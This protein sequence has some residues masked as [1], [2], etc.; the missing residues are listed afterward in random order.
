MANDDPVKRR[1]SAEARQEEIVRV[2]VEL[3]ASRGVDAVTTQ[4]MADALGL[5]QGAIFRHFPTKD[6]IWVAVIGWVRGQ[7]LPLLEKAASQ[8]D[9]PIDA[10][11][12]MFFAHIAFIAEHPGIPR[13]VFS[14]ELRNKTPQLNQLLQE[15]LTGYEAKIAT[16]LCAAKDA[17]LARRDLDEQSAATLFLGMIQG[18]VLQSSIFS[19]T[20]T[21]EEQA[22]KVFP[23]YLNGV[24]R[25]DWPSV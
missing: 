10:L 14:D 15:M 19:G 9:N 2:A 7:L 3:A 8:G 24:W 18:L 4:K 20:R 17:G 16:L 22:H 5:T 1:L 12:R 6:D 21:L 25:S 11:E 23:V 13:L